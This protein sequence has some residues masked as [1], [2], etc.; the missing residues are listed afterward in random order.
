MRRD[1]T[2]PGVLGTDTVTFSSTSAVYDSK[3]AGAR[4]ISVTGIAISGGDAGNYTL[5]TTS[6]DSTGTISKATITIAGTTGVD[7]TY[8]TTTA[9]PGGAT[10]FTYTGVLGSDDVSVG[11][12]SAVYDSK[13]AGSRTVNVS[14][15][16]LSGTDAGNYVLSS[17]GATGSGTISKAT[18]TI[19]GT[20]DVDKTYDTTT[21]LPGGATGFTYTGVLGSDDVSVG[22]SSAVYDSKNAGSRTVNVSG[23]TLSG[24]DAGN[25]VLS[26]TGATGSGTISKATITI[27][28]TTGVDKT[29]DTTTALPG[30]ATGFT[31]TGVLGSDDVSVG[32]SSAVYDSKNAGSRTVNV[33][34]LTLSGTDAGNYVLSS[35]GATGSGTI[36]KATIT[37]A[38][39]TDVDRRTTRPRRCPAVRR[40]IRQPGCSARTL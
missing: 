6:A 36:S 7:K 3:N 16:T 12:S 37:I 15:L 29:Y 33:S 21:A 13:N 14:G 9:L 39:T 28:G 30:G 19:A 35:T 4:T 17:T 10:G 34:G 26:S 38:G 40:D 31:Y 18:I 8:D 20:T 5:S 24:T 22:A 27:A 32:A 2:A 1:I 23:L 25:Y 11:A